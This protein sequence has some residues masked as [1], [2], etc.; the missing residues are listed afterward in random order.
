MRTGSEEEEARQ[1]LGSF[2][3]WHQARCVCQ[4]GHLQEGMPTLES[5]GLEALVASRAVG[6]FRI[7]LSEGL[8]R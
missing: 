5:S 1:L 7:G 4:C 8:K 6:W 3:W 2:L